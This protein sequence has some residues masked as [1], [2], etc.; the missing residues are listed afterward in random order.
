MEQVALDQQ[1]WHNYFMNVAYET[2][3][4]SYATRLKVGS[5]AVRDRR[6]VCCG[7]NGT[8]PGEDNCCEDENGFTKP[9]VIHSEDNLIRF[10]NRDGIDLSS[11]DIYITHSPCVG[12]AAKLIEAKFRKVFYCED[13]RSKD[14]ILLLQGAGV[15]IIKRTITK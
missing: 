1:R 11:C 8:S 10:A 4:L 9:N 15:E 2:A 13:Y 14:G 12:C 5:V 6:I 7:F 3:K